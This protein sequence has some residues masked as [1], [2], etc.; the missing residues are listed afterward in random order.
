MSVQVIQLAKE[1]IPA[2]QRHYRALSPEDLRLRFGYAVPHAVIRQYLKGIDFEK[3][4]VFG[5]FDEKLTLIGAAHLAFVEPGVAE[6]GFSVLPAWRKQGVGWA[7]MERAVRRARNAGVAELYLHCLIDNNVVR[8]MATK[9]GMRLVSSSGEAEAYLALKPASPLGA[10]DEMMEQQ[11][12]L[13][14]FSIKS[15]L[16]ALRKANAVTD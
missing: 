4:A 14:D 7:L 12:A 9:L 8:H 5:V 2:L 15:H 1:A 3:D 16:R 10:M 11:L 6:L 13:V